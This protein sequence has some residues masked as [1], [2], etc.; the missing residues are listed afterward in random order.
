MVQYALAL[1]SG[2]IYGVPGVAL[3][4][5]LF[6]A[7]LCQSKISILMYRGL[8]LACVAAILH[9]AFLIASLKRSP[10]R[11]HAVA[12]A[13]SLAFAANVIFL[14][15]FPVTIDRSLTVYLLGQLSEHPAGMTEGELNDQLIRQYVGEY[16]GV[17]RRMREQMVTG[18]VTRDGERFVLTPQG[19]GFMAFSGVVARLFG[20]DPRFLR[21]PNSSSPLPSSASQQPQ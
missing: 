12:S 5:G 1:A 7:G 8:F 20:V 9:A 11:A 10:H 21:L 17:S 14:V 16:R 2:V 4:V 6:W 15:V 3:F 18:N 19:E 13:V